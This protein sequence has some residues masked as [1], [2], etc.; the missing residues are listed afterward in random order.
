MYTAQDF[1]D[2]SL[3]PT[4]VSSEYP[5][6]ADHALPPE[7]TL[8]NPSFPSVLNANIYHDIESYIDHEDSDVSSIY[9]DYLDG[10]DVTDETSRT[11]LDEED[12][13][14]EEQHDLYTALP[15][16]PVR[17]DTSR[18]ALADFPT[19]Q[20][21]LL[22]ARSIS[23]RTRNLNAKLTRRKTVPKL[24]EA[25]PNLVTW[26]S[27][28]DPANPHNWPR[29]RRWTSTVL[30]AAFAFIA[31]MASTIV[32]P[33]LEDIADEF[34]I[35]EGSAESFLVMS[36]FLLAFAIG[37]FLWGP[38]SEVFGRVRVM[39]GA[40][41]IFLLFNTVC[42]FARSKEQMMA[43]RFLSGIGGSAPQAIGGGIIHDCFKAGE[44]GTA[45]AV[46]SL[47]PFISP[48]VAPIM[49]GYLTQYA[50]WRW[51]F[52]GTS[53]FDL[54]VQLAC[55]FFLKE[56][57]APAILAKKTK[58][59]KQQTGNQQLHTK[60]QGPDHTTKKL[61]MKSLI[62]PFIM[63]TTQPALQAMAL[64]RAYQYGLMYLVFATFPAVFEEVYDQDV[65]R[66]SLNYLSLGV[67]FVTGLQFS[68]SLQDKIF[69]WCKA[70][71]IDPTAS[72]F[73]KSTWA[74][75]QQL[76]H[77]STLSDTNALLPNTGHEMSH[78]Q[79][80]DPSKPTVMQRI[81]T[82]KR[83]NAKKSFSDDPTK[84]L[85]EYRLPLLVPFSLFIPIGLFWYGWSAQ[86]RVHWIVPNIGC[87]I[88]A[89][90]LIVCFNC[91]QA[92]VV[93]T[94]TTYSASAT[95]AAAF[96][97][98]MAGFSFP[99]FAPK[100]YGSLGVGWGNSVLGFVALTFG[101]GAPVLL[102]RWGGWLRGRS[103]YC[104]G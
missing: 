100:M 90:G 1:A 97:R 84:G 53:L 4:P 103:T 92:Y 57:F 54:V 94:Y 79:A 38:L 81:P 74:P 43:F 12:L 25:D 24:K 11:S 104:T 19:R 13:E 61:V 76:R 32:A 17:P 59:L 101:L 87:V 3:P 89:M 22:S 67:G 14:H 45:V 26:E 99:L 50:T 58:V 16:S 37:P 23:T 46:Y 48:A 80:T 62:R 63:L 52:W 29:H 15:L 95:G 9:D 41:L 7:Y 27:A 83:S 86:A 31:P 33:A 55:F 36:I 73:K 96:V 30:I 51:A 70:Q 56:T 78:S 88:F 42:G 47:M 49:G 39:Q 91:A 65:G 77:L 10:V 34:D 64:Y 44:R 40:N 102:W 85:P 75:F 72:I 66:A 2:K 21:T 60:W 82:F 35:E 18:I 5:V 68:K 98:T 28:T 20:P 8:P 6:Q 71:Q 69:N 93:D